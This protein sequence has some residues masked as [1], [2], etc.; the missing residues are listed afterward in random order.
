M[1]SVK[2]NDFDLHLIRKISKKRT[3]N[4][5][6]SKMVSLDFFLRKHK[7]GRLPLKI[8][9]SSRKKSFD[10]ICC[11]CHTK[12]PQKD[13]VYLWRLTKQQNST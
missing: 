7:F 6:S 4:R 2:Q 1:V 10:V 12:A 8:R 11:R 3:V 9:I 5:V 13:C